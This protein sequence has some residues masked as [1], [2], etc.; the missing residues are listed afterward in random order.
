MDYKGYKIQG[1]GT[2]GLYEVKPQG[3]GTVPKPLRGKY[4]NTREAC[5]AID[6]YESSKDKGRK[7]GKT[8]DQG[9]D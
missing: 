1:D 3:R 2:F 6:R 5:E 9:G 7:N 8:T 4:T